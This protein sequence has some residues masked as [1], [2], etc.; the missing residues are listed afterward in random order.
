MLAR[1]SLKKIESLS[2]LVQRNTR[3]DQIK[4]IVTQSQLAYHLRLKICIF[5]FILFY[6]LKC[7]MTP[8]AGTEES[9]VMYVICSV[10]HK[11]VTD[12]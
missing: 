8:V 5:A 12:L 1:L 2:F 6:C 9:T 11:N 4:C 10:C 3:T 7:R